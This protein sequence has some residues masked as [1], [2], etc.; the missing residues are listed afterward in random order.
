MFNFFK[1]AASPLSCGQVR[2]RHRWSFL[3][4]T[5]VC[6]FRKACTSKSCWRKNDV[7]RVRS[8]NFAPKQSPSPSYLQALL[9]ALVFGGDPA[10]RNWAQKKGV[11]FMEVTLRTTWEFPN[12]CVK[13]SQ[14][15]TNGLAHNVVGIF[16]GIRKCILAHRQCPSNGASRRNMREQHANQR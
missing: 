6:S 9:D 2:L 7:P 15:E 4:E 11:C 13:S 10:V 5:E 3:G 8:L 16:I 1:P 12:R 14:N